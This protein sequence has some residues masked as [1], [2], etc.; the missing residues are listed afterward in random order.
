MKYLAKGLGK[1]LQLNVQN[2]LIR[3]V[4]TKPQFGLKKK[5]R[6]KNVHNA[7]ELDKKSAI[8]K[9]QTIF[10]IDDVLTT[11]STLLECCNILKRVGAKEVYGLT[12]V[13]D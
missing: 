8:L 4:Q 9:N 13:I 7:F 11:G 3:I 2:I 1:K 12:L 6:E 10:L 5:E